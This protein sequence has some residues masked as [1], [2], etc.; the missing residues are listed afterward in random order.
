MS[1]RCL[2][3]ARGGSSTGVI[4]FRSELERGVI[5][6]GRQR[7]TTPRITGDAELRVPS[8]HWV[9]SRA[10]PWRNSWDRRPEVGTIW[11]GSSERE[12]SPR[13]LNFPGL[14][15]TRCLHSTW[16]ILRLWDLSSRL[17]H[18]AYP[19]EPFTDG[20]CT[21]QTSFLLKFQFRPI[22]W[23]RR[24]RTHRSHHLRGGH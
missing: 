24:S 22:D 4:R 1:A 23:G 19:G 21:C 5:Q 15:T 16:Q 11:Y 18:V 20:S 3:C 6:R 9:R 8:P 7:A 13:G 10:D 14:G 12:C 17:F 2:R